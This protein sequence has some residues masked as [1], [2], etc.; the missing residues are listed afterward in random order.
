MQVFLERTIYL[1]AGASTLEE[2]PLGRA[3]I[4]FYPTSLPAGGSAMEQRKN[5]LGLSL[6]PEL[7]FEPNS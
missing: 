5:Y 6:H 2:A 7:T 3:S 4:G 1:C